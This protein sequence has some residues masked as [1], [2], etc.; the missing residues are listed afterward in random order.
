MRASGPAALGVNV[1][2]AVTG[3]IEGF[4]DGLIVGLAV[5]KISQNSQLQF[6]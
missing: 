3:E 6:S 4:P 5:R 1:G 2:I